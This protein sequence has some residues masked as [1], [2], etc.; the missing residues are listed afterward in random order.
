[1][2]EYFLS[3]SSGTGGNA[4][5]QLFP[6]AY[7][8]IRLFHGSLKINGA[9]AKHD[10]SGFFRKG[11]RF[12]IVGTAQTRWVRF[13]LSRDAPDDRAHLWQKI[14]LP[15]I[16]ESSE[17]LFRLDEVTFPPGATAYRHV[18]PGDGIRFLTDGELRLV[19]DHHEEL[20]TPGHAWFEAANSPVRAEASF[21]HEVT[22]FVRVMVL[23]T[24]YA[25]QSTINI[26]DPAEAAL[27]RQQ[28]TQRH[29]DEIVQLELG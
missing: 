21:D 4:G 10:E 9:A 3:V 26:L 8:G 15:A 29:I 27:E 14:A 16:S 24:A 12:E 23:P 2:S 7:G 17:I 25:G 19:S 20:A 11:D 18:H 5:V 13:D 28:V 1:M 6:H 22:R